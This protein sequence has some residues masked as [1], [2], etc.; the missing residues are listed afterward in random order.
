[1]VLFMK[2]KKVIAVFYAVLAA[3]FYALNTP[4]SKLL[5]ENVAPTF[6]AAFLYLGAGL[7]IG[8][9]FALRRGKET[10]ADR[11]ERKDMP[12]VLGMIALDIAAPIL[13]MYGIKLGSASNA[14]LLG[15]FEIVATAV[16]ALL[17]FKEKVTTLLWTAIGLIT[18]S[19]IV[20]SLEGAEGFS[21]SVGSLLVLL[22]TVC[23]GL[24]N[25]CTRSIADKSTYRIVTVK[26]LCCGTGSFALALLAGESLPPLRYILPALLLG[27]VAYGLSIFTYIRAQRELGAAKTSAYYALAPFI[28]AA[29]SF[30]LLHDRLTLRY[31]L[32]LLI[33][34][35]GT[36]FVVAD[37]LVRRHSH[38]HTHVIT[39]THNGV[40]H[41]HIIEHEHAHSH[42]AASER[43][44]HRLTED[45]ENSPEHL[46][47]HG[48][49]PV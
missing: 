39:H 28:G 9:M 23:W 19:G 16:I 26:G 22:A 46:R 14:S 35:A 17:L 37:T 15:N 25:N 32:A 31:L 40:E 33:M 8:C 10:E 24:E 3:F 5:L 29:L 43:H 42:F 4:L 20:L 47:A 44:G 30:A 11:F 7:G 21:F 38:L 13:L 36:A 45:Y 34:L 41:T 1:M 27:F 49:T 2:D 18:L 48:G 6:M 12:Y